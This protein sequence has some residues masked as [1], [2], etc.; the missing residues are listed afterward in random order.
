MAAAKAVADNRS[1][2]RVTVPPMYTVLRAKPAGQKP[3]CWTGHIYD[4]SA[5]GMRMEL[6]GALTPGTALDLRITLPGT[7]MLTIEA[8]GK[9]VRLHD[10]EPGPARMGIS[11]EKFSSDA[12]RD[13][14][15]RYLHRRLHAIE[16]AHP[17]LR[18]A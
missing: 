11:F 10:P 7:R 2:P 13:K 16:H 4:I 1:A 17:A 14:L 18:A 5:S 15:I 9:V 3:Y 8:S 12:D 6:D